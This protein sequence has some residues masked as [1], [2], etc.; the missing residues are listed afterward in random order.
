MSKRSLTDTFGSALAVA[1]GAFNATVAMLVHDDPARFGA[2]PDDGR[3]LFRSFGDDYVLAGQLGAAVMAPLFGINPFGIIRDKEWRALRESLEAFKAP[4]ATAHGS[5]STPSVDARADGE[6][7][8][9]RALAWTDRRKAER[10][11]V[12]ELLGKCEA[13]WLR[14]HGV[15]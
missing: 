9:L 3:K 14:A 12:D 13:C 1:A 7:A 2:G 8:L 15:A 4:R 6:D 11:R 10:E 5:R